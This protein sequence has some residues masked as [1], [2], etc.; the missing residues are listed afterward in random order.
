MLISIHALREESDCG[1]FQA[2]VQHGISIHAL[3]EESDY[4][5]PLWLCRHCISIHALREESDCRFSMIKTLIISISIHALR[6]ES[7]WPRC[8]TLTRTTYF[9]PRSP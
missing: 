4:Q 8:T 5:C 6:E 3:R 2:G 7:D 9:Y 1:D